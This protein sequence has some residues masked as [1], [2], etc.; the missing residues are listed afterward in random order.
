M[1]DSGF[2][3]RK[4]GDQK[5][6]EGSDQGGV[7]DSTSLHGDSGVDETEGVKWTGT[8]LDAPP[9]SQKGADNPIEPPTGEELRVIKV[10]ADLFKSGSFKLQVCLPSLLVHL[11]LILDT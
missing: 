5:P 8:G 9:P 7:D 4:S 3:V 1:P 11:H 6:S 2:Q 10:A